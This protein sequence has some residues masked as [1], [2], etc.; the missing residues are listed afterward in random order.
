[1]STWTSERGRRA[2]LARVVGGLFGAM[3][4]G[5]SG[6]MASE[7]SSGRTS[8]PVAQGAVVVA[9]PPGYCI[10]PVATRVRTTGGFVL[11]GACAALSEEGPAPARLAALTAAVSP[12]GEA[13][14]VADTSQ[15][16]VAFL[17]TAPGRALLSRS[18]DGATVEVLDSRTRDG[19]LFL[20]LRDES[21]FDGAEVT[22]DYWRALLDVGPHVVSLS[23]LPL[24]DRP[25]SEDDARALLDSFIA[26]TRKATAAAPGRT[27]PQMRP[28]PARPQARPA[29]PPSQSS[30]GPQTN[31]PEAGRAGVSPPR[32]PARPPGRHRSRADAPRCRSRPQAPGRSHGG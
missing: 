9:G 1:M 19:M 31:R 23:V 11:L 8:Q 24:A 26:A 14:A 20:H 4:L 28:K 30:N 6:C 27:P 17:S 7:P 2:T 5:L 25:L 3:T 29:S 12:A 13:P 21:P 22:A 10:D 32:R 15:M 18:G 16:L